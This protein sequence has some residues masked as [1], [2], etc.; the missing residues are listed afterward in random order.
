MVVFL[1]YKRINKQGG[2]YKADTTEDR[3]L[4]KGC[5]EH[6]AGVSWTLHWKEKR[7]LI[8]GWWVGYRIWCGGPRVGIAHNC[9]HL[10]VCRVSRPEKGG[11]ADQR[12]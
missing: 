6:G 12:T 2:K 9:S 4:Q 1:G 3:I 5:A 10:M 7:Q 11:G 8:S